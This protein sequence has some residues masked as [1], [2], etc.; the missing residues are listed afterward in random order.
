MIIFPKRID[1]EGINNNPIN[2]SLMPRSLMPRVPS[3]GMSRGH[4]ESIDKGH[5]FIY[6]CSSS[7]LLNI[8]GFK[9]A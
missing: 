2:I 4:E 8:F 1:F 7:I 6:S 9:S 3:L 5:M